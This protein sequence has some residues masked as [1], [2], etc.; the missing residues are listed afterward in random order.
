MARISR[1]TVRRYWSDGDNAQ[2]THEKG[3]ALE[4]LICYIFK[5][6]PG[7][8][9]SRRNTLNERQSQ[10]IDIAFWNRRHR[11]GFY[12]LQNIILVECKNWSR[13]LGSDGVNWFDSKLRRRAQPFG[14]LIA[15]NGITGNAAD[16]TAEHDAISSA[17]EDGRQLVILTRPEINTLV[18]TKQLVEL[19]QNKL[20]ELAVSGTLFS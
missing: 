15:A 9:V 4:D 8:T 18:S 17:L 20:C 11:D 7:I 2:T 13:P 10:E 6:V 14:I 1:Q 12:F 19:I 5:K 3:K 16:K